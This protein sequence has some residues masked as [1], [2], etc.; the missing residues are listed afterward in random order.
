M[1][2][3]MSNAGLYT[4]FVPFL[5]ILG[6]IAQNS[7]QSNKYIFNLKIQTILKFC[8]IICYFGFIACFIV[9]FIACCIVS[10][11]KSY[12]IHVI[13]H[14]CINFIFRFISE[15]EFINFIFFVTSKKDGFELIIGVFLIMLTFFSMISIP[16]ETMNQISQKTCCRF[17]TV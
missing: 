14:H 16:I 9:C 6:S 11:L 10:F 1:P 15:I 17:K 2:Y 7:I 12:E 8:A 5:V 3:L 4:D 13:V